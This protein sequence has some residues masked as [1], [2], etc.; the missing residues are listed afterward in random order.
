MAEYDIPSRISAEQ[1]LDVIRGYYAKNA[2]EEPVSTGE[3]EDITQLTDK[4]GRQTKFLHDIGILKSRGHKRE[5][6]E[7]G[8]VIGKALFKENEKQAKT[9]LH[10]LLSEWTASDELMPFIKMQ[11]PDRE[12]VLDY[13]E[14]ES[15]SSDSRGLDA[16]LDLYE[17]AGVIEQDEEGLYSPSEPP[18][19]GT[20]NPAEQ[21]GGEQAFDSENSREGT[22]TS[23]AETNIESGDGASAPT[24]STDTKVHDQVQIEL[25][26]TAEDDPEDIKRTV[27]AVREALSE[28]PQQD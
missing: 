13:L 15:A 19:P 9:Q 24:S 7:E 28:D 16:L 14:P 26:F 17:W 8:T 27:L 10:T 22:G 21:S 3:V 12:E 18:K 5:L 20:S 6:T 23:D 25:S 11:N 4:V 1:L 2:H